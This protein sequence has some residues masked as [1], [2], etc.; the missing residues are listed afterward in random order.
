MDVGLTLSKRGNHHK[1][2]NIGV[3]DL[4]STLKRL[5]LATMLRIEYRESRI[6]TDL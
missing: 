4:T 2:L 3:H 1:V 6:E 5:A